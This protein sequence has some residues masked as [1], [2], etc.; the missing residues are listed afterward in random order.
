[1][2]NLIRSIAVA[3]IGALGVSCSTSYDS[4]G[5]SRQSVSPG[6]VAVGAIALGALAYSIGKDNG[7]KKEHRRHTR[8]DNQYEHHGYQNRGRRGYSSHGTGYGHVYNGGNYGGGY[9]R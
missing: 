4:Y 7:K 3:L 9:G 6:G 5:N 2:K 1:M 8:Y